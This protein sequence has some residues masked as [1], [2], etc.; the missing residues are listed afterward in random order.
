MSSVRNIS[1]ICL[2]SSQ[3][4]SDIS[5]LTFMHNPISGTGQDQNAYYRVRGRVQIFCTVNVKRSFA[6]RQTSSKAGTRT[7]ACHQSLV[8]PSP[9]SS[10]FALAHSSI[11]VLFLEM[12]ANQM[13]TS[14]S[15]KTTWLHNYFFEGIPDRYESVCAQAQPNTHHNIGVSTCFIDSE[16]SSFS[17]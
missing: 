14:V 3:S 16:Q 13:Q 17:Y 6:K 11:C 5:N 2:I 12:Q 15:W 7:R 8:I 4:E 1:A 9:C 10:I